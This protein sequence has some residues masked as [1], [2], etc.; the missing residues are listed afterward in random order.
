MA[1]A[2]TT[3]TDQWHKTGEIEYRAKNDGAAFSRSLTISEVIF[4]RYNDQAKIRE[5][6]HVHWTEAFKWADAD[7]C[8]G[9]GLTGVVMSDGSRCFASGRYR[10]SGG[11]CAVHVG[12]YGDAWMRREAK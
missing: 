3:A 2:T 12:A 7:P 8:G 5:S 10:R 4:A 6:V 1:T 9:L 11:L